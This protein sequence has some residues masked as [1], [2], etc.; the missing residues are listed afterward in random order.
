[1]N[2]ELLSDILKSNSEIEN[3][4]IWFI[5]GKKEEFLSYKEMYKNSIGILGYLQSVGLKSR[6]E[7]IFQIEDNKDFIQ[8][9]WACI[10]GGIIPV[11]L[12]VGN[13]EENKIRTLKI[14]TTLNNPK[15]ITNKYNFDD[16]LDV[17]LSDDIEK[18][19]EDIINSTIFIEDI[20]VTAESKDFPDLKSDDIAFIQFS[21]GSTGKPKGVM[22]TH[23]NLIAN[24]S[25]IALGLGIEASDSML[26]WIPLT[27]DMGLIGNHLTSALMKINQYLIVTNAFIRRPLLWVNK[28]TEYK[29]TLLAAPNF[30]FTYLLDYLINK[31]PDTTNTIDLSSVRLMINGAEPVSP[32]V[33]EEFLVYMGKFNLKKN[34][35]LPAYGLAE[36]TVAVTF[37]PLYE[38]VVPIIVDRSSL[39]IGKKV[40]ELDCESD[41]SVT[42]VDLGYPVKHCKIRICDDENNEA[43]EMTYGHIQIDGDNATIGYY[44]N[45]EATNSLKTKDGWVNTG[46]LGFI[47]NGR[48]IVTGRFKDIIIVN[49]QNYYAHDIERVIES[50]DDVEIGDVVACA[51]PNNENEEGLVLFLLYK[52]DKD[53][54]IKTM[55]KVKNHILN[56]MGLAAKEVVPIKTIPKTMSG[57]V[58]R[59]KLVNSYIHGE[60]NQIISELV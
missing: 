28:V 41:N 46:D 30:G 6:D 19:K 48:L 49:G 29:A 40:I 21:S 38:G 5:S 9:F 27:H 33:C 1:M 22:L 4:G 26:G 39:E 37:P 51:V 17:K 59:Y 43:E 25:D 58:Q 50:I 10:M 24:T 45:E 13:N 12:V 16:L 44:N 18:V 2:I 35:M 42:F 52:D 23:K 7:L 36:A 14:W 32:K 54:F 3:K 31:A 57:K 34:V 8:I 55:E 15:I 47:R 60:Y 53:L 56:K 20:N 11:P